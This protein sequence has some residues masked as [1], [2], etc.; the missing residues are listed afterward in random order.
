MNHIYPTIINLYLHLPNQQIVL[1]LEDVDL[2]GIINFEK[3]KR[4]MLIE[5]FN[6]C[7]IDGQA[8]GLLHK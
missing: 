4:T 5:F 6:A 7:A 1:Y 8:N 3:M 2:R